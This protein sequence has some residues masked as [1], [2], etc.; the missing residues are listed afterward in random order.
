MSHGI[1]GIGLIAAAAA[2][3][4]LSSRM[5]DWRAQHLGSGVWS[6]GGGLLT[7]WA[8]AAILAINGLVR[9]AWAAGASF[10]TITAL[11]RWFT[12]ALGIS[13]LV[14][15]RTL[16][17][18][19]MKRYPDSWPAL[20]RTAPMVLGLGVLIAAWVLGGVARVYPQ[21]SDE[22]FDLTRLGG[23]SDATKV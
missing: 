8:T 21:Q 5:T 23:R 15:S 16:S 2:M 9:L 14:A 7:Q 11:N 20:T 4:E 3:F 22:R 19:A 17:A 18:I 1:T 12:V 6:A 13:I 10:E